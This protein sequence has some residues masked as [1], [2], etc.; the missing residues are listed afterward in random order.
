ASVV[1]RLVVRRGG[2]VMM[3]DPHC[4][5]QFA[6]GSE[7]DSY[8]ERAIGSKKRRNN[9]RRARQHLEKTGRVAF[10]TATTT[11]AIVKALSDFFT[12]EAGGWK[13][14]FGSA[15]ANNSELRQFVESAVIGLAAEGKARVDRLLIDDRAVAASIT[16]QSGH[17][18]WFWKTAYDE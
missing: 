9:L 3:L 1:S 14:R 8:V 18:A 2:Q 16:F 17:E 15:A 6:P 11:P 5:G 4:R 12:L 13:G 10:I 7:R